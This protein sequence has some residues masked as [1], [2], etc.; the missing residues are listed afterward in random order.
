MEAM[1]FAMFSHTCINQIMSLPFPGF[2]VN[3]IVFMFSSNETD[4]A[5]V[6]IF[7]H[8]ACILFR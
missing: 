7:V 2:D 8:P 5:H 1:V 6:F 4:D 3:V